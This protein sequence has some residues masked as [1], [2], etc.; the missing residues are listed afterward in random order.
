MSAQSDIKDDCYIR[1][2]FPSQKYIKGLGLD[3]TF[4]VYAPTYGTM[5][6]KTV[7]VE[8]F[9]IRTRVGYQSKGQSFNII[10]QGIQNP[11]QT[12]GVGNFAV[13]H[14]C[15]LDPLTWSASTDMIVDS[16]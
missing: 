16:C 6:S 10:I 5:P 3:N 7:E 1:I 11:Y 2:D 9:S 8:N 13:Y 12:G 14:M 4:T 15:N